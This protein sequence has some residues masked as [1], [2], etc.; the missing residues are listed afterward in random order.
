ML[1]D[2]RYLHVNISMCESKRQKVS[3]YIRKY[4]HNDK[5]NINLI[6]RQRGF[7]VSHYTSFSKVN[8]PL[9]SKIIVITKKIYQ[10][11]GFAVDLKKI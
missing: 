6:M 5:S 3:Q 4:R 1:H 11:H 7:Q 9:A 2:V 8:F 10:T